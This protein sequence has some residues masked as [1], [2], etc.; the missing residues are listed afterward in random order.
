MAERSGAIRRGG[1]PDNVPDAIPPDE[2]SATPEPAPLVKV[3]SLQG[4]GFVDE[5]FGVRF[6]NP[7]AE[8]DADKAAKMVEHR[9][10]VVKQDAEGNDY[11]AEGDPLY[12][13]EPPAPKDV[14]NP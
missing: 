4:V 14:V 13:L 5:I 3:Y 7:W 9:P 8:V 11:F 10:Q 6:D 12:S 1:A 2:T